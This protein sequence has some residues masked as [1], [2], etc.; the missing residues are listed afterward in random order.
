MTATACT[1][2]ARELRGSERA[3]PSCGASI[4]WLEAAPAMLRE[5]LGR[6]ARRGIGAAT[7]AA[8]VGGCVACL[9]PDSGTRD[10]GTDAALDGGTDAAVDGGTTP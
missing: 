4:A 3:C 1:L 2:C 8:M 10:G 9:A 7:V 5:K 6:T